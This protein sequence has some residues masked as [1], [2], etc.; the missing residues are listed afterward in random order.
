M[1]RY[2]DADNLTKKMQE[3]YN[4]LVNE[5]GFYDHFTE[6]YEDALIAVENEPTADVHKVR[7][8]KWDEIR[9]AYG[10]L[11]GWI[12]RDCGRMSMGKDSYC[13]KCGAKMDGGKSDE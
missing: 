3:R 13:P 4:N 6:G 10:R 1:P 5:H 12:H 7:H 9:G 2:I 8:G 11:E